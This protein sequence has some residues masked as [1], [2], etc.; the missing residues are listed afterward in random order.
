MVAYI[1]DRFVDENNAFLGI[2]DLSIQRGFGIFDFFRTTNNVPLFLEDYLDRFFRS[3][4]ILRI[5]SAKS[6][7]EIKAVIS[8]LIE[9]N[10]VAESGIKMILTGGY[11]PDG[12]E[13]AAPNFIVTQQPLDLAA[14]V[15]FD[16]GLKIVLAEYKRDVPEAKSIN[17]LMAL[18]LRDKLAKQRADEVLYY[19]DKV[20]LEFPRAN[21]FIITKDKK[22][23]TPVNDV[24][25]GITRM[26]VLQLAADNFDVEERDVTVAEL[27]DAAE[28]F[29]TSTTKRILPVLEIDGVVVGDGT[30]GEATRSLYKSFLQF[31]KEYGKSAVV[32]Q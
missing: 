28:V 23:V 11:S 31:E 7:E 16:K 30:P 19:K 18:Y 6:R 9:R 20:I 10:D 25:K 24:L 29:L 12:F 22:V 1:N 32:A 27:R 3:A 17:Y 5:P 2:N 15:K 26:K 13:P 14:K 4:N 21:V 8:E